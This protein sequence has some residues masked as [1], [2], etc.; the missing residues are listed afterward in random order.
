[1]L[2]GMWV[3]PGSRIQPVSSGLAGGIL[4]PEPPG[5]SFCLF[6]RKEEVE[7]QSINNLPPSGTGKVTVSKD[8]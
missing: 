1:M 8:A 3:L 5:K 7:S 6:Y 4:T 2:R